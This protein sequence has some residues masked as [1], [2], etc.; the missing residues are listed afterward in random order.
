[1]ENNW[2]HTFPKGII[3][4]VMISTTNIVIPKNSTH[5]LETIKSQA[6]EQN[7]ISGKISKKS[8]IHMNELFIKWNK[9]LL[10]MHMHCVKVLFT[11]IRLLTLH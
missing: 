1:M 2:I 3:L 7:K 5:Y 10:Q 9:L 8:I 6:L 11:K 4:D